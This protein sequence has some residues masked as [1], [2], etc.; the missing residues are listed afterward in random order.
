M[1]CDKTFNLYNQCIDLLHVIVYYLLP[2]HG[3][4]KTF[5]LH[6][7]CIDLLHVIVYYLLPSHGL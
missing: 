6:N 5:N 3:L 1:V 4:Y 7:Q 2:S